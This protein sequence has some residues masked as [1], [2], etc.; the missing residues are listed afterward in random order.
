MEVNLCDKF[1]YSFFFVV[2]EYGYI[3]VVK[4][5]LN[6]DIDVNMCSVEGLIFLYIFCL[7][8][9]IDVV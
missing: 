6:Y 4:F 1:G 3:D 2:C 8:K 5:L 9:Y 7:R